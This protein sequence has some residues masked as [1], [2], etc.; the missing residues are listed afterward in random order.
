M[1]ETAKKNKLVEWRLEQLN[2]GKRNRSCFYFFKLETALIL[3]VILDIFSFI[4]M[5]HMRGYS[6]IRLKPELF[7][8]NSKPTTK[9]QGTQTTGSGDQTIDGTG[10]GFILNLVNSEEKEKEPN[11]IHSETKILLFNVCSDWIMMCLFAVKIFW[12]MKFTWEMLKIPKDD[13][14]F[15]RDEYGDEKLN[16]RCLTYKRTILQNYYMYSVLFQR[17]TLIQTISLSWIFYEKWHLF[18]KLTFIFLFSLITYF[19][20]NV[21][22][23][24]L[25]H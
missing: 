17:F 21:K 10:Q 20:S 1:K 23:N 12:G 5:Y 13:E 2:R 9:N 16:I 3:I 18:F 24:R 19:Y 25:I 15:L 11:H 22:I 4:L 6:F 8:S 7:D 14:E